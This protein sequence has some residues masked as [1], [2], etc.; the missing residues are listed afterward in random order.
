MDPL[1]AI[2]V[3]ILGGACGLVLGHIQAHKTFEPV[4]Q[5]L[6][7]RVQEAEETVIE[8]ERQEQ[9]KIEVRILERMYRK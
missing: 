9:P 8:L 1:F 2:G 5:D 4:F 7:R 6:R 3:F